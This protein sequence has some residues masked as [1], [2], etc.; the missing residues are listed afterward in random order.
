MGGVEETKEKKKKKKSRLFKWLRGACLAS[1]YLAAFEAI[2][3]DRQMTF[4]A[5]LSPMRRWRA[6]PFTVAIATLPVSEQYSNR[7]TQCTNQHVRR[8]EVRGRVCTG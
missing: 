7:R 4:N 5:V 6:F 8:Q 1:S 3:E 2:P